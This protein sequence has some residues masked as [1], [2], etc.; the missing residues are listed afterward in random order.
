M[1]RSPILTHACS[2]QTG[3]M[4]LVLL[5]S[6]AGLMAGCSDP[7]PSGP[8]ATASAETTQPVPV[9]VATAQRVTLR[10]TL[11]LVGQMVAI[12]ERTAV[13]SPQV[14]GWV[15]KLAV[16]EGQQVAE[17]D[18]LVE[19][20]PRSAQ[21][22]VHRAQ[23]VVAEKKAALE[24]LKK[25]YLPEEIAAARKAAEQAAATVDGLRGELTAL[26]GLL[27]RQEFSPV[28]YQTKAKT[29]QA[30]EA[31]LASAQERVKLLEA[32]TR[33]ERV[34]Q[35]RS[36]LDAAQA[37]LEQARLALE[38]CTISSPIDG[39][40]VQL[41]ARQGQYFDRAIP[42]ATIIDL[43]ELFVK[44][45]V[46][47]SG[48][49]KVQP[50]TRVEVRLD[51]LP[52]KTFAGSVAR[53]GGQADLAT[54]NMI[55]YARIK[56]PAQILRPGFSCKIRLWLPEIAAALAIPIAAVADRSGTPV[57]TVI[58][59]HQAK[60]VEVQ[61]GA[62]TRAQVEILR[63]LSAGTLVATSGGYGL[64]PGCPVRILG[65]DSPEKPASQAFP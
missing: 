10:P 7:P 30:A 33:P 20:D 39:M 49:G 31:A 53:L 44:L 35:A 21:T 4:L 64:P 14:G 19:L 5:A 17:D 6:S 1:K 2:Q 47:R 60:E 12:P 59:D 61:V 63:G 45:R 62:Q 22:A 55:V 28:L 37:D 54:G 42:L 8:D 43:T 41:L 25:G 51:S 34:D 57:V 40:V 50:G 26:K 3:R 38:W 27:D 65:S 23:A 11:D 48:F 32:G 29:L 58:Q 56:N 46:P 9:H 52:G 24:L 15:Q 13:V 36:L 16:V 18:V